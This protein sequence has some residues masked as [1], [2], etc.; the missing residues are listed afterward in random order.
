MS[1]PLRVWLTWAEPGR[2]SGPLGLTLEAVL[3]SSSPHHSLLTICMER[4][5]QVGDKILNL[6][7]S[8][9]SPISSPHMG[10]GEPVKR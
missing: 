2:P 6:D 8:V 10:Q 1:P 7:L 4:G 5:K 9:Y 3:C